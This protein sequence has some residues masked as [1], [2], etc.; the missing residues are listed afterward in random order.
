MLVLLIFILFLTGCVNDNNEL[1]HLDLMSIKT[2]RNDVNASNQTIA[3]IDS[4]ISDKLLDKYENSIVGCYNAIDD[5]ELVMDFHGHGSEMVNIIMDN[6]AGIAP[7]CKLIII[8]I[9]DEHG[10]TNN[11][12]LLKG[13]KKSEELNATV[14]NISLGGYKK[15]E[16]VINQINKMISKN[17]SI[18]SSAGDYGDKDLLFPANVEGVISV[19]A[20]DNQYKLWKNCNIDNNLVC[21]FPGVDVGVANNFLDDDTEISSG[22]KNSYILKSGTSEATVIASSYIALLRSYYISNNILFDNSFMVKQI[23]SLKTL[24]ESTVDYLKLFRE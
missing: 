5:T 3:I 18:V 21:A 9:V 13:L 22:N 4:G 7:E 1:W 10:A 19:G 17:I 6:E 23:Q 14:I 15:D 16:K 12:L 24:E 11:E 20:F 8:K 2:I